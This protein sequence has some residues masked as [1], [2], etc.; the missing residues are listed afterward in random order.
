MGRLDRFFL[1]LWKFSIAYE[2]KIRR[3]GLKRFCIFKNESRK[4]PHCQA[5]TCSRHQFRHGTKNRAG[6]WLHIPTVRVFEDLFTC[7]DFV[8]YEFSKFSHYKLRLDCF[9]SECQELF[10]CFWNLLPEG[11]IYVYPQTLR[12]QSQ[13]YRPEQGSKHFYS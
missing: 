4:Q 7:P 1:P 6:R 12:R 11:S 10:F 5:D 8:K 13:E 3:S 9:F 2:K